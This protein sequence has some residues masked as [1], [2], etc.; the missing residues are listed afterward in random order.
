MK[1]TN[2]FRVDTDY[3]PSPIRYSY[4]GS[5]YEEAAQWAFRY[6]RDIRDCRKSR[7]KQ[8]PGHW[9]VKA[10]RQGQLVTSIQDVPPWTDNGNIVVPHGQRPSFSPEQAFSAMPTLSDPELGLFAVD[11]FNAMSSQIPE[12]I[13][14]ANFAL[15][16]REITSLIPKLEQSVRKTAASGFL[17]FQFGWKPLLGDLNTLSRIG[18]NV[19]K[20]IEFLRETYGKPTRISYGV[21]DFVSQTPWNTVQAGVSSHPFTLT[22]VKYKCSLRAV[23]KLYHELQGLDDIYTYTRA[24]FG[25]LGLNNPLKVVWN[26]LPYSFVLDWVGGFG[27]RLA[28][29]ALNPFVGSWA[30]YDVTTSVKEVCEIEVKHDCRSRGSG[31]FHLGSIVAKRYTRHL[32]FPVERS[33]FPLVPTPAQLVLFLAL[34]V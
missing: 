14:I 21:K 20:R 29:F 4:N 27:S 32:G 19:M 12:E 34:L 15:E 18:T 9:T 1:G 3:A 8:Q 26:A 13:S 10:V 22:P 2:R 31:N 11:A 25:A 30:V 7:G 23:G 28:S 6:Y 17:N 24:M 16:A 33:Y 5:E